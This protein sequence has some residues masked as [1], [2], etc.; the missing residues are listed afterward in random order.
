MD[1]KAPDYS[2][3]FLFYNIYTSAAAAA[4]CRYLVKCGIGTG[5]C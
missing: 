4:W 1:D 2:G 3:A 5:A